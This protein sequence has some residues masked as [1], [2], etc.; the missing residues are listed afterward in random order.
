[1]VAE[2][3]NLMASREQFFLDHRVDSATAFRRRAASGEF[4]AGRHAD[5]LLVIDGTLTLRNEFE[6]LEPKVLD[7]ANRGLAYGIHVVASGSRW[8]DLRPAIR[9]AF[10]SKLELRLGDPSDSVIGRRAAA[11]VPAQSPGRG[12]TPDGYQFLSSRPQLDSATSADHAVSEA[13]AAIRTAWSGVL[14]PPVR[15][16]PERV[17][18]E[19]VAQVADRSGLPIGLA[20]ADLGPVYLDADTDPHFVVYGDTECGKSSFLRMLAHAIADRHIPGQARIIA[21]DYRRSLLGTLPDEHVIGYA[22]GADQGTTMLKEAAAS[23]RGRLPGPDVRPEQLRARDWWTGADLYVLADDYD[24]VSGEGN[25]LMVLQPLLAQSRE[26]GLHV[27]IARRTG[28]A[29]RASFDPVLSRLR[30]L[31]TPGL[32]MSGDRAEGPLL[33]P[34]RPSPLPPGRAWMVTRKEGVR[35]VQLSWL[36]SQF[37]TSPAE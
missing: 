18:Y 32:V 19:Q 25:P 14:A 3:A 5:V 27:I 28:G 29:A 26:V 13:A 1:V 22:T 36:D 24:L 23:L 12:I 8:F 2:V 34:V 21:L 33:G 10:G 6:D 4:G 20:E 37:D 35:L 7:L 11:N 31:N 15:L 16:L 9:D 30:D 17:T